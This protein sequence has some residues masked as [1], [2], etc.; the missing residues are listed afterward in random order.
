VELYF[1]SAN[2]TSLFFLCFIVIVTNP[3]HS[4]ASFK[5]P[6][7][8][9]RGHGRVTLADVATHAGVTTMTVSRFLRSPEQVAQI[10]AHKIELALHAT[11]YSPNLQAGSLASGRSQAVAVIVPNLTHSIFADTLHGLGQGLQAEG[12][13]MLVSSTGYSLA[14]EEQQ[15]RTV[16]GWAPAAVVV[17]G[18]LHNSLTQQLLLA[19]QSRGTPV[20]EIWDQSPSAEPHAFQQIGFDHAHVGAVMAQSLVERGYKSLC[21]IDSGVREDFRA[22][23]R[24]RGFAAKALA[25]GIR[26]EHLHAQL[27]DPVEMGGACFTQWHARQMR[28]PHC[29]FGFAND[30]LATG[31]LLKAEQLRCAVPNEVGLL[32]FGDFPVGRYCLGGLSTM[33]IDGEHIGQACAEFIAHRRRESPSTQTAQIGQILVQPRLLWR[34]T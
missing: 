21:F 28:P 23:E 9:R 13:H 2:I 29:G 16:L 27:G 5:V 4:S 18:R 20:V 22:H 25:F 14:S 10:T 26:A 1:V 17:T 15:V 31:A 34:G 12:L 6:D 19:A 11:G 3:I 24:A 8:S 30:L 7:S 33:H 32:G